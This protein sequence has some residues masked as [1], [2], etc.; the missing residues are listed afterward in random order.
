MTY[1]NEI[2]AN[3]KFLKDLDYSIM[4]I[5]NYQRPYCWDRKNVQVLLE[6]VLQ[7]INK[8][9]YRIGSIILNPDNG[10]LYIVDGQQRIT[11]FYLI[12][13][14]LDLNFPFE[15]ARFIHKS[16]KHKIFDNYQYIQS[17]IDNRLQDDE[18][19]KK[20]VVFFSSKCS[21]NEIVVPDISEA[22][23]MFDSQ[24]G[25][26]K[27][28]E[29]HNLLKAYHLRAIDGNNSETFVI[30]DSKKE[31]DR[32]W[33]SIVS[34][35]HEDETCLMSY[36]LNSLF[37][38]RQW[39]RNSNY[40]IDFTKKS[41]S[42]FK[43]TQIS[44]NNV[45]LPFQN[46]GLL[47]FL[48]GKGTMEENF[49]KRYEEEPITEGLFMNI[50][51]QIVNGSLFFEYVNTYHRLY[52]RLLVDES[53]TLKEFR[54]NYNKYCLYKKHEGAGDTYIRNV[55]IALLLL[56]FDRFGEEGVKCIYKH[57]YATVYRVR[58][59]QKAVYYE[60]M[61][62][63]PFK[64]FNAIITATEVN[65]LD[66]GDSDLLEIGCKYIRKEIIEFIITQCKEYRYK[67]VNEL[68]NDDQKKEFENILSKTA[69]RI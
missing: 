33:E 53:E 52:K 20:F 15:N 51:M 5:P 18:L 50:I 58:L 31:I 45:K 36:L 28:L 27:E 25:R 10:K 43:G 3:K 26:G 38:I 24:N 57:L 16:S 35:K 37:R 12:A 48:Y 47:M 40:A 39:C 34:N 19:K 61:A 59:Q 4:R 1:L 21:V 54:E 66:F 46:M 42:E 9:E 7:N 32:N 60:T 62:K 30:N 22:F 14:A 6:S 13:K 64:L 2:T 63:Y 49:R 41:L 68:D 11:T 8:T 17:W 23:Q 69:N 56:V 55:Y 44:G 67:I 29:A 65:G